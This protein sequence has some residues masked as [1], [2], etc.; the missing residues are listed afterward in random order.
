[1]AIALND[2]HRELAEVARSFLAGQKARASA[3]AL[4]D[5]PEEGLPPF[6]SALADL[7][8]LGI[9]LP[10][11]HGGSGYGLAELVVVLDEIG[12]AVAPGPFLPTVTAS[13]VIADLADRQQ[14]T[15]PARVGRRLRGG[16]RRP[17]R[18]AGRGGRGRH[19]RRRRRPRG[20]R[21]GPPG[22]RR[23][24]RRAA[25]AGGTGGLVVTPAANLDPSRRAAR[26]QL[27]GVR[28][29]GRGRA[30]GR[31]RRERWT[32]PGRSP[33]PRPRVA[34]RTSASRWRPDT[35]RSASSSAGRSARS[36]AVK[37]HCANML[38]A[39][40]LATAAVWDAARAAAGTPDEFELAAAIAATWR[41]PRVSPER[42][43]E[44]PGP[45]RHRLH[46][47]ARRAPASCA[48]RRARR[49]ARRRRAARDVT[50]LTD[51]G[52]TARPD[53]R[54][55][56]P[57][58][59]EHDPGRGAGRARARS[60]LCRRDAAADALVE[61]GYAVPHWPKPWGR[62]AE[63][64]EQIVIDEELRAAGVE[65]PNS[66][67]RGWEHHDG[68]PVRDRRTRS[69]AGSA[70]RSMG[71]YVWCQLF[72]E[73]DAGSDA[74]GDP[75]PGHPGRRAAGWSTARRCGRAAPSTATAG[76]ATVRTD[77]DAPKHAGITTM[78][79]DMQAPGV[80]VRPAARDHRRRRS[81]TR[82][83]STTS[84]CPTTTWSARSTTAGR[85]PARRS[86]TSG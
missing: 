16:R 38:V 10:E 36:R 86:A 4:L 41:S 29:G 8:W 64:V 50:R 21:G 62:A 37:H 49:A 14:G 28:G 1:M 75:D 23:R 53:R 31:P 6:W 85:S 47:G 76:L 48:G 30:A 5:A 73:P 65:R 66:A 78:V 63:A 57:P 61:T 25:P 79:I 84:S 26:V 56:L 42:A 15:A 43:A 9:H 12:R 20:R 54:A 33:R 67:S 77:P 35:P 39:A 45:R 46:L 69:S 13:A 44:H 59:A 60:P 70:R 55:D 74:A 2:A 3:R 52:V 11:E 19:G 27:D 51:A 24:R 72:S 80:E 18:I 71:E 68:D 22:P 40:E 82:C 32:W 17:R 81:S 7:G 58:E 34:A 83:S